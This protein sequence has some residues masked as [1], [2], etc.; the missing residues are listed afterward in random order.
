MILTPAISDHEIEVW[1]TPVYST[2][3]RNLQ[4]SQAYATK[5]GSEFAKQKKQ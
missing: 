3:Y 2:E 1:K 4:K 5:A